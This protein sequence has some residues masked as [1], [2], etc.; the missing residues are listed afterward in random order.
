MFLS[1]L[2]LK[3]TLSEKTQLS[4]LLSR[5]NYGMHQLLYDIFPDGKYLFRVENSNDQLGFYVLSEQEPKT[6]SPLFQVKSKPFQPHIQ[7]GDR[8]MFD[9]RASPTVKR[10]KQGK[11]SSTR[12]D[13]ALDAKS[14]YLLKKCLEHDVLSDNEIYDRSRPGRK[15]L[16]NNLNY[17]QLQQKLFALPAYRDSY[18]RE[19]FTQQQGDVIDQAIIDWMDRKAQYGGFELETVQA[20]DYQWHSLSNAKKGRFSS[21]DYQ[22]ILQVSDPD[23]FREHLANGF[24]PAKRFGCGLMLICKC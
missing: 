8:F 11:D 18:S 4:H 17:R 16:R 7:S 19:V 21:V 22:G 15:A 5:D 1:K 10:L 6:D 24:G 12:H 3:P 13:I 9:L 23:V 14:Q 2:Q 20:T